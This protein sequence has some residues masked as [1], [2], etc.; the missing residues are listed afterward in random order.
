MVLSFGVIIILVTVPLNF[1]KIIRLITSSGRHTSCRE[2]YK[3]LQILP[4]PSQYIFSLLVFVNEIEVALYPILRFMI[5]KHVTTTIY[6]CLL[7]I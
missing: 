2:L 3:K 1:K 4:L 5:L 6:I 7:Q